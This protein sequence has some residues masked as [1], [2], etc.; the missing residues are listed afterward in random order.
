MRE[1]DFLNALGK[2]VQRMDSASPAYGLAFPAHCK[3]IR[4]IFGLPNRV[5][6]R[7]RLRFCL[8]KKAGSGQFQVGLIPE[9]PE[10]Q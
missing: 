2:L 3:F 10:L 1:N 5:R 9:P 7:L 6:G 4:L 8:V